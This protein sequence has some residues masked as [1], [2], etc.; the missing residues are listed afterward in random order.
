MEMGKLVITIM[1]G[2]VG[3]RMNSD[4]PKVLHKFK[5]TPMIVRI[6]GECLKLKVKKI[7]IITGKFDVIIRNTIKDYFNEGDFLRIIF[8]NQPTP[9]GTADPIKYSLCKYD[10]DE[11]VLILNGDMPLINK[12]LLLNFYNYS[13]SNSILV[14]ELEN[15]TG[16]GRIIYENK[17]FIKIVEEK[18][19]NEEEKKIKIINSG[20]YKI[21]SIDL[22]NYIPKINN[23]N[24]Q[25][26]YYLTDIIDLLVKDEKD[27]K[28][29]KINPNDN[30]LILGVNSKEQLFNLEK[31]Y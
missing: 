21:N 19:C 24:K 17:K 31:I 8:V 6:L 12:D 16:Y 10:D 5:G 23:N 9:L 28:T 18:D 27:I 22:K 30:K 25:E 7:I 14:A 26:E 15:S 29:F 11:K 1:A 4:L 13:E 20:V 2:G 3:K